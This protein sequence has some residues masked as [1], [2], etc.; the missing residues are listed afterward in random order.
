MKAVDRTMVADLTVLIQT[1][2]R[3]ERILSLIRSLELEDLTGIDVLIIDNGSEIK[4][5]ALEDAVN[6][7]PNARF[8][9]KDRNCICVKCGQDLMEMV[10]TKFVLNPGDD[11][12]IVP[13]SLQKLRLSILENSNFDVLLTFMDVVNEDGKIIGSN[14]FPKA[15]EIENP[16]LLLARLLKANFFAWPATVYRPEMFKILSDGNFRY[17]TALDWSFW[18]LNLPNMRIKTSGLKVVK[19]VRHETNESAVVMTKQQLQESESMRIR[20]LSNPGLKSTLADYSN[21]EASEL[22]EA[23]HRLGGLS[24]NFETNRILMTLIVQSFSSEN[25]NIWEPYLMG[26]SMVPW[27]ANSFSIIHHADGDFDK[28]WLAYPV[29]FDFDSNSCF[30][31]FESNF[32]LHERFKNLQKSKTLTLTCRCAVQNSSDAV[33]VQC[34]DLLD[35]NVV[36]FMFRVLATVESQQGSSVNQTRLEGVEALIIKVYRELKQLIPAKYLHRIRR[37]LP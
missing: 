23:I 29:N 20:A 14:F 11:D 31:K 33:T 4:N 9:R 3:P 18:I 17:R 16:R 35:I 28:Y 15:E 27:D 21:Q 7:L 26:L 6:A 34:S 19:Y 2:N 8:L 24:G 10:K 5:Q 1:F 25:Q 30:S 22:V 37:R 32:K 12:Q 36:E 13:N